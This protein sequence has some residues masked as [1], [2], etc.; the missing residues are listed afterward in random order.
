MRKF[1]LL[2]IFTLGFLQS[3]LAQYSGEEL[4]TPLDIPLVLAGNFGELRTGHFHAGLDIKTLHR[5]GLKVKTVADGYVSRIKISLNGYGKVLYITHSNGLTSVYAHLKKFADPIEQYVKKKQYAKKSFTIEL[6]LKPN[7]IPVNKGEI[8][9]FSGNTGG[10]TAPHLHFELRNSSNSHPQNP[11]LYNFPIADNVPPVLQKL[12]AYPIGEKS[13]V[14][15]SETKIQIPFHK[16]K[17][18]GYLSDPVEAKGFI[19]FGVKAFDR[20]DLA[21]NRNGVYKIET[22][23]GK[24]KNTFLHFNNFS[25]KDSK[26]INSTVDYEHLIRFRERILYLFK[27]THNKAS[28]F[29]SN[30]SGLIDLSLMTRDTLKVSLQDAMGNESTLKIPLAYSSD[31]AIVKRKPSKLPFVVDTDK[32]QTL[33]SGEFSVK[34]PKEAVYRNESIN[35]EKLGNT[36]R[37]SPKYIELKNPF[38]IRIAL[39]TTQNKLYSKA[40]IAKVDTAKKKKYFI[41]KDIEGQSLVADIS[42]LGDYTIAYDSIPPLISPKNFQAKSQLNNYNYLSLKIEDNESGVDTYDAYLNG[43]WILM[44]YEP[45][46]NTLTYNFEDA[47]QESAKEYNLRVVVTDKLNNQSVY[48]TIFKKGK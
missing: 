39:D 4:T 30:K 43:E 22:V 29:K 8:I 31:S 38:S 15:R 10:S 7:E 6:F 16:L 40:Y 35:L 9:A 13:V 28:V 47:V 48:T 12:F 24:N 14:N 5:E 19:G 44:E 33:Y 32:E 25:F 23:L 1:I 42:D 36:Y 3:L 46:E 26:Y 41:S 27:Q 37:L 2:S 21:A 17:S 45:K 18:G 34:I 11:I 20:Q